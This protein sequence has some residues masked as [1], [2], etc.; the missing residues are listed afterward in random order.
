VFVSDPTAEAE[1]AAQAIR[2]AGYAVADV[3]LAMLLARVAVQPPRVVLIDA[4]T[5]GAFDVVARLRRVPGAAGVQVILLGRPGGALAGE[6][7]ASPPQ[8]AA[9]F[10]R[11]VDVSALVQ[12]IE[13]LSGGAR[14]TVEPPKPPVE[15]KRPSV[16][17]SLPPASMRASAAPPSDRTPAAQGVVAPVSA[18]LQHLLAEAE[19]RAQVWA[20]AEAFVPSPEE[21]IEAVLPAELLAALDEP[22]GDGE[23]DEDLG[24]RTRSGRPGRERT[25]DGGGPRTTGSAT[26]GSGRTP[27]DTGRP[28]AA[29]TGEQPLTPSL[30]RTGESPSLAAAGTSAGAPGESASSSVERAGAEAPPP[31]TAAFPAV[32]GPGDGLR[33]AAGA[34]AARA[35]GSLCATS[36]TSERRLILR[37]GDVVTCVSTAEDESLLAFLG[38]RGDLPRETVRRLASKFPIF[39]R[40]AGAALVARG[41]LPQGQMWPTL[42]AH[43]EWVMGH[44]LRSEGRLAF[45]LEIPSRFAGEPS[46]FGGAPGAAVFV[47]IVRRIVPASE[48]IERLGGPGAR[49]ASGAAERLLGECGLA[50]AELERVRAA[51]GQTLREA[52]ASAPDMDLAPVA[53]ALVHLGVLECVAPVEAPGAAEADGKA[54]RAIDADAIRE[55]VRARLQVVEDGDYFAVLGIPRNATGYEIRRAFLELRRAFEPS[56]LLTPEVADLADAARKIVG[57]LEEAYDILRDEARRERYR[58]AIEASPEA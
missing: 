9:L 7:S 27:R 45:E 12:R 1:R 6:G 21:E 32:L 44:W 38:V 28:P 33:V 48:A 55:R 8:G 57:V 58:S 54:A 31:S 53:V 30:G 20:D 22:L 40:H 46:V 16:P 26:T 29:S 3:P 42:R 50:A 34:I 5:E 23:D 18:E 51:Q 43:A 10:V 36:G 19:Q 14:V 49:L 35:S 25:S 41:Y 2:A 15:S 17:P 52:L 13:A 24:P 39:G 56:R 11:P 4:D 37:E 47:E